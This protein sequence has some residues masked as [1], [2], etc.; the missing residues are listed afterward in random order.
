MIGQNLPKDNRVLLAYRD[1][2]T[3]RN[4]N[5]LNFSLIK[6]I[7][8]VRVKRGCKINIDHCLLKLIRKYKEIDNE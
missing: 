8:D 1:P 7:I 4:F 5:S 2:A 3:T 6:D